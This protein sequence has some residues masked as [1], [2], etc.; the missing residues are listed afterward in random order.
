MGVIGTRA[1][2]V[3]SAASRR[4]IK[5]IVISEEIVI[6]RVAW[7][8]AAFG[9]RFKVEIDVG[10]EGVASLEAHE[11]LARWG[12]SRDVKGRG[13]A[14]CGRVIWLRVVKAKCSKRE[15]CGARGRGG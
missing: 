3:V 6:C 8:M 10:G 1:A 15:E 5:E 12:G 14:Y 13:V 2:A 7:Q 11:E 9:G 4:L